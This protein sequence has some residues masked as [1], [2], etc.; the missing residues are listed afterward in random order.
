VDLVVVYKANPDLVS[1]V[2]RLL[3][4]NG[5]NPFALENP[6]SIALHASKGTYVIHIAVPREE[7]RGARSVLRKWE[8]SLGPGVEK[9]TKKLGTQLFFSVLVVILI[10]I[11]FYLSGIFSEYA[12]PL[13]FFIWL[14]SFAVIA[15]AGK[16][17]K[18]L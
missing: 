15:N 3:R 4:E 16:I 12:V 14:I 13:L 17:L 10:S 6:S 5:F 1:Q 8:E 18:K 11:I 2:M 7:V 9:L